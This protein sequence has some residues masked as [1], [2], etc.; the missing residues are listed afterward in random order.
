MIAGVPDVR[1]GR[2]LV[3]PVVVLLLGTVV[4]GSVSLILPFGRDQGIHAFIADAMLHGKVVYRDVFNVKPPLTTAVH[5]LAL[6]AFGHSMTSIRLLDMIWSMATALVISLLVWRSFG[7][8]WLACA[9][10]LLFCFQFYLLDFWNTAQTD[11]WINLPAAGAVLLAFGGMRGGGVTRS[12][13]WT[14]VFAGICIGLATMF[15]YTMAALL[16][17][18]AVVAL[19]HGRR[20]MPR[21]WRSILW[22]GIG[23]GAA[24]LLTLLVLLTSGA[25][26]AFVES[27]FGLMPSYAALESGRGFFGKLMHMIQKFTLDAGF[28]V[29]AL[30]GLLGIGPAVAGLLERGEGSSNRRLVLALVL[31]W[32][33]VAVGSVCAQGKFFRYHYLPVLGPLAVLG[34]LAIAAGFGRLWLRLG[35]SWLRAIAL[36][37]FAA[38]MVL[39]TG[40]PRQY[41]DLLAVA[42]GRTSIG[43]HWRSSRFV[44]WGDFS[45]RDDME[46]ADYIR[47]S[48]RPDDKVF[49]WGYEPVV[50]FLARRWPVSRF[51]YT[52]P[53]VVSWSSGKFQ[54][55]LMDELWRDPPELFVVAH[56][57]ATPAVMG[58]GKDSFRTLMDFPE[59]RTY[60]ENLYEFQTKVARFDVFRKTEQR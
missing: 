5:A 50:Y 42:A 60:V 52:F 48:T 13:S 20:Q 38:G 8:R 58:H 26:P 27:Q 57:D 19:V 4:L 46:L 17:A 32:L 49:I 22:L 45:L 34:A 31:V 30:L 53:I 40:Y 41:G 37:L 35:R 1:R 12:G 29:G 39:A 33:V 28:R 44:P 21:A 6:L 55:E 15:K 10:G 51:E 14:W 9:A 18:V 16:P 36:L 3:W 7:R 59:L 11:G 2:R 23:F 54:R 56:N 43:E 25:L 47:A 24:L